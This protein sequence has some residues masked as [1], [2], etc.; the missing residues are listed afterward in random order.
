M[1]AAS[2]SPERAASACNGLGMAVTSSDGEPRRPPPSISR[3]W[4]DP[5]PL[6]PPPKE[7]RCII[8]VYFTFLLV[9]VRY[10]EITASI[11]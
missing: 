1:A 9:G 7:W 3:Y 11:P 5:P 8:L 10:K 4:R 6:H 2:A